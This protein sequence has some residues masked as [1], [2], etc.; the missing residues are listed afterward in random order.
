MF[1]HNGVQLTRV[2]CYCYTTFI[3]IALSFDSNK[4]VNTIRLTTSNALSRYISLLL[5]MSM[6]ETF[7]TQDIYTVDDPDAEPCRNTTS[8]PTSPE[9]PDQAEEYSVPS[10]PIEIAKLNPYTDDGPDTVDS[11]ADRPVKSKKRKPPTTTSSTDSVASKRSK[12]IPATKTTRS[13][14]PK[15]TSKKPK[16]VMNPRSRILLDSSKGEMR[17]IAI[18]MDLTDQP[19]GKRQLQLTDQRLQRPKAPASKGTSETGMGTCRPIFSMLSIICMISK[20]LLVDHL[21]VLIRYMMTDHPDYT[22]LPDPAKAFCQALHRVWEKDIQPD[23]TGTKYL[24]NCVQE[25]VDP[26]WSTISYDVQTMITVK[27]FLH[28]LINSQISVQFIQGLRSGQ[29]HISS[30]TTICQTPR[31]T[32]STSCTTV[33]GPRGDAAAGPSIGTQELISF[34]DLLGS[35]TRESDETTGSVSSIIYLRSQEQLFKWESK[36]I[37]GDTLVDVRVYPMSQIRNKPLD[38]WWRYSNFR[39]KIVTTRSSTIYQQLGRVCQEMIQEVK[40]QT[41]AED[42]VSQLRRSFN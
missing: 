6:H 3:L 14:S 16:D 34:D 27:D 30:H 13:Q 38:Q 22:Q 39:G 19:D 42:K 29:E 7:N 10:P 23:F 36:K 37:I 24:I 18:Q 9:D 20:A 8:S 1:Y 21:H 31:S 4:R 26:I 35:A 25:M 40:T 17:P 11:P 12:P 41:D 15:K 5:I 28:N 32:T 33:S 2:F